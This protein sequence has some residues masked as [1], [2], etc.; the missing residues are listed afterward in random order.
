[1]SLEDGRIVLTVD[2]SAKTEAGLLD[3]CYV[4]ETNV[5]REL[6]DAKTVDERYRSL[7]KV[8][9]NFRTMKTG[10]LEIRPLFLRNAG[11]TQGHALVS[12]LALKI[13][14]EMEEL[15]KNSPADSGPS[16]ALMSLSRWCFLKYNTGNLSF[17]RLQ[18]PDQR[19]VS[20]LN[21]LGIRPPHHSSSQEPLTEE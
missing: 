3:G 9:R 17:L 7:Q 18:K 11:R 21:A 4:M 5:V 12:M 2:E 19:Q 14:R 13:V 16:D 15:L 1:M 10:F 8:E 20:I 6:L